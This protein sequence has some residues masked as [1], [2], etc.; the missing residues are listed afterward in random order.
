MRVC[1]RVCVYIWGEI[2]S[3]ILCVYATVIFF[4]ILYFLPRQQRQHWSVG[5][6][7]GTSTAE[8]LLAARHC[9]WHLPWATSCN[10]RELLR[11]ELPGSGGSAF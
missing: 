8:C 2:M 4:S 10:A 3:T 1:V 5:M 7:E 9:V 6:G 11:F